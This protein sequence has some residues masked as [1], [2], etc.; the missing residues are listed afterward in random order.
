MDTILWKYRNL[1]NE[2]LVLDARKYR[3]VINEKA[4]RTICASNCGIGSAGVVAGPYM[5][6][7]RMEMKVF[8]PYGEE[9]DTDR[10]AEIVGERYL[11]DAGYL[12]GGSLGG[13][14]VSMIGKIYLSENF[15]HDYLQQN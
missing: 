10:M 6:G 8:N 11:K 7:N 12:P 5:D 13:D 9:E 15:V 1:D 14:S 3:T 2:Y 4:V